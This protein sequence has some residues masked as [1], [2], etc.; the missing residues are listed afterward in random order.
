MPC[1]LLGQSWPWP[2]PPQL[3]SNLP[4]GANC[5]T[6][7]AAWQQRDSGGVFCAPLSSSTRVFG[8]CT[9]QTLS[10]LS[11]AIPM[12]HPRPPSRRRTCRPALA[13]YEQSL[14]SPCCPPSS[15]RRRR[16]GDLVQSRE[17]VSRDRSSSFA[18]RVDRCLPPK[19]AFT[20]CPRILSFWMDE[21]S[22]VRSLRLLA[23]SK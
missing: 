3:L 19:S 7:G 23:I 6:G 1:S 13:W 10:S 21:E 2:G 11:T 15:R 14:V 16:R 22:T 5:N 12:P 18:R 4:S 9:I 20:V 8:R 17:R